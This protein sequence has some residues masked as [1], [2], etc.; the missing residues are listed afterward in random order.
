M[1]DSILLGACLLQPWWFL[2]PDEAYLG[3]ATGRRSTNSRSRM[4]VM[5]ESEKSYGV[6]FILHVYTHFQALAVA[7]VWLWVVS[8]RQALP[9]QMGPGCIRKVAES[10]PLEAIQ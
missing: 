3:G 5:I 7:T 4:A 2:Y 9:G 8:K 6:N 10:E 1:G